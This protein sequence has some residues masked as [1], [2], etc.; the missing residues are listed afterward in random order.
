MAD[1]RSCDA[2]DMMENPHAPTAAD[3]GLN[4]PRTGLLGLSLLFLAVAALWRFTDVFLLRLG[5][6]WINIMP[7]K[8]FPLLLMLYFFW[9]YSRRQIGP[10]LGISRTDWK[11]AVGFG[12]V[13]GLT[14]YL[15]I[16]VGAVLVYRYAIDPEYPLTLYVI[17]PILLGYQFLFFLINALL[18]ETLFRGLIQNTL[19]NYVR[20]MSA[21]LCSAVLFSVWHIC[22]PLINGQLGGPELSQSVMML[23][24]AMLF[25]SLMGLY[26][27][28][29][30]LRISLLGPIAAHTLV[31]FLNE[32]FRVGVEPSMQGP[33]VIVS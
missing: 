24:F 4:I 7:S 33:D 31:N 11:P 29:F 14:M 20:P 27:E 13:V 25:G 5:D 8:L 17:E 1:G 18:E 3:A 26:Y 22:W 30:F 32:N 19:R 2:P 21:I 16:K 10:V 9:R 6:T 23:V 15:T 12:I 28:K